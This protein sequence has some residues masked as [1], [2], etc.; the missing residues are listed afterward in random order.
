MVTA[1]PLT[2]L[3]CSFLVSLVVTVLTITIVYGL[4]S[5]GLH[6]LWTVITTFTQWLLSLMLS[7][8]AI[9]V[10]HSIIYFLVV[11]T[12]GI[13]LTLFGALMHKRLTR[14]TTLNE[15]P[16]SDDEARQM[17]KE[18]R[19]FFCLRGY[20]GTV[21]ICLIL[22]G[23]GAIFLAN[24]TQ[25]AMAMYDSLQSINVKAG[26]DSSYQTNAGNFYV[27]MVSHTNKVNEIHVLT[28]A[29]LSKTSCELLVQDDSHQYIPPNFTL[30]QVNN[31]KLTPKSSI[32]VCNHLWGNKVIFASSIQNI[33]K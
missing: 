23:F 22:A 9:A 20:S 33:H 5:G 21:T 3:L 10:N 19:F 26:F 16:Y 14:G 32:N 28:D 15:P 12:I 30:V 13:T 2:V 31:S 1:K 7:V 24:S 11:G 18:K 17:A 6:S 25:R 4:V 27:E 29:L 8:F